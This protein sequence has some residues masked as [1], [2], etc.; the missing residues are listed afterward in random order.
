ML[1]INQSAAKAALTAPVLV[2][3]SFLVARSDLGSLVFTALGRK[4]FSGT[5]VDEGT[6]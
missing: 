6:D 1:M 2:L 4:L 3:L 5:P